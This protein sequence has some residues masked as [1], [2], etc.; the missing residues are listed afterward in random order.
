[1]DETFNGYRLG[2]RRGSEVTGSRGHYLP[3]VLSEVY[4]F[5]SE[6]LPSND[7]FKCVRPP[8]CSYKFISVLKGSFV[9]RLGC[10]TGSWNLSPRVL[11]L[12]SQTFFCPR[13]SSV[14][15]QLQQ[16]SLCPRLRQRYSL[17]LQALPLQKRIS[18][19]CEVKT[20]FSVLRKGTEGHKGERQVAVLFRVDLDVS[21]YTL[22][23]DDYTQ[24][25][26]RT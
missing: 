26:R 19:G 25:G 9:S 16:R 17:T 8:L 2:G 20:L 1:M 22:L 21:F 3:Q 7:G 23:R 24:T 18:F 4:S 5:G 11:P 14:S 6:S 15:V 10:I 13:G 12:S